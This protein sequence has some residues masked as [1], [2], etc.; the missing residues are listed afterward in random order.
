VRDAVNKY[1][2]LSHE[3]NGHDY[4]AETAP[5]AKA[6][7]PKRVTKAQ[8]EVLEVLKFIRNAGEVTD[9]HDVDNTNITLED[10]ANE[11]GK[12]KN[13]VEGRVEKATTQ[14][15]ARVEEE[16]G[17]KVVYLTA[18]GLAA[19]NAEDPEGGASAPGADE[20]EPDTG[21]HATD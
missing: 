12:R 2:Y 5:A 8:Q 1:G 11:L 6:R 7:K 14:G 17:R 18:A 15:L 21:D 13:W 10:I 20:G 3:D 4:A 9:A 16:D 19:V